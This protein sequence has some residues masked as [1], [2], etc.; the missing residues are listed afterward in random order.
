MTNPFYNYTSG[1]PAATTRGTSSSLRA[2]FT[3][4][5]A[6]FDAANVLLSNLQSGK[7]TVAGQVWSGTHDFTGATIKVPT[8]AVGATGQ[9]AASVDYVN[10]VAISAA[11]P[12]QAGNAG[13]LVTTDGTVASFSDKLNVSVLKFMDGAANTKLATLD[14]TSVTAGQTRKI[15]MPDRDVTLGGFSNMVVIRSTQTWTPPIGITKAKITVID[16]GQSGATTNVGGG[17]AKTSGGKGGDAS[18]SIRTV[19]SLVAYT[20]AVGLGGSAPAAFTTTQNAGGA[21]SF[22]GTGLTTLTSANGDINVPGGVSTVS[23]GSSSN[24]TGGTSLLAMTP[25]PG[26]TGV[27]IGQGGGG[28]VDTQAGFAGAT[29]AII[30]EY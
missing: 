22:S 29:G 30:I 3:Q 27:A 21:S 8:L 25:L 14:L 7:G 28:S 13:K 24:L 10:A 11:L 17:T 18:I 2:E 19:S 5:G 1:A 26:V 20:A 4:I 16:G 15:I 6:G 9:F 23:G 12:G